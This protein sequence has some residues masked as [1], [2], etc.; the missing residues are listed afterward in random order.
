MRCPFLRET[1]MKSCR[2]SPFR[3]RIICGESDLSSE[4]CSSDRWITCPSALG[5]TSS[6]LS[7]ANCPFLEQQLVQYCSASP[8][9]RFVPYNNRSH[10]RCTNS[11]H[12]YCDAYFASTTNELPSQTA[13]AGNP[14]KV[15]E[16]FFTPGHLWI[17]IHEDNSCHIGVDGLLAGA[18]K[19]IEKVRYASIPPPR[20]P[21]AIAMVRGVSVK[22]VFPS[23]IHDMSA[24]TSLLQR[25]QEISD[26]PYSLGWLFEGV[27]PKAGRS[28]GRNSLRKDL[29]PG[30]K[31]G[32]WLEGERQRL[33]DFVQHRFT[34][35]AEGF[36]TMLDGGD[37]RDDWSLYLTRGQLR[38]L[39]DEFFL[40]ARYVDGPYVAA[41]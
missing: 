28:G 20:C 16:L 37:L 41:R 6:A 11:G 31:S 30:S 17:N 5:C 15:K 19:G 27:V 1:L 13:R 7:H 35:V 14:P 23:E 25:P 29:L 22:I 36:Q 33:R 40:S 3:T 12:A 9:S 18:L 21:S 2:A 38:R 34:N 8:H 32:E 26:R 24:N 39:I 4:R 10:S